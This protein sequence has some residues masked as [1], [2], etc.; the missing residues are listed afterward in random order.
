MNIPHPTSSVSFSSSI[1]QRTLKKTSLF[2]SFCIPFIL[3]SLAQAQFKSS[4]ALDDFK[5]MYRGHYECE[6]Q[7]H[8]LL[9]HIAKRGRIT[10]YGLYNQ[11]IPLNF[12]AKFR[13]KRGRR[14]F[15][16]IPQKWINRPSDDFAMMRLSGSLRKDR[17]R[18]E[19]QVEGC[20]YWEAT[21][22]YCQRGINTCDPQDLGLFDQYRHIFKKRSRSNV[23]RRTRN[24]Q[25]DH[26]DS[27]PP[28]RSAPMAMEGSEF[29]RFKAQI[30]DASFHNKRVP[31]VSL[32]V[33]SNYFTSAQVLEI[34]QIW[35]F[36]NKRFQVLKLLKPRIIDLKN[37][38]VILDVFSFDRHRKQAAKLLA[39]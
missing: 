15:D 8:P 33:Q 18:G 21:R 20:G 12:L 23:F 3:V 16:L 13:V 36:D 28:S 32:A 30:E 25:E 38:Y 4:A 11:R 26:F 7:T 19:V 29:S 34:L 1:L 5:G 17:L 39:Q 35:S 22:I 24:T 2:L 6:N 9:I 14:N 31:I 27:P 10:V 37:S